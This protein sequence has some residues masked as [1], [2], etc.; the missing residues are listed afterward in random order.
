MEICNDPVTLFGLGKIRSKVIGT[1]RRNVI[2]QICDGDEERNELPVVIVVTLKIAVF[3]VTAMM[4]RLASRVEMMVMAIVRL[5]K[6]RIAC[7]G[8]R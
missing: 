2:E 7:G 1:Q 4:M 6:M 5:V 8:R 3:L